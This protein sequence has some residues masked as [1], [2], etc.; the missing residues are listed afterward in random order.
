MDDHTRIFDE[1]RP[2]LLALAYRMLCIRADAEDVLQDAYLRWCSIELGEE[3]LY[4]RAP[5][6]SRSRC[7]GLVSRQLVAQ[8]GAAPR[9]PRAP[10]RPPGPAP[11]GP[12]PAPRPGAPGPRAAA[13]AARASASAKNDSL[14]TTCVS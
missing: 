4:P 8:F 13:R 11:R 10:P 7:V 5:K 2:R 12:A 6:S 9:P 3:I 14:A 1:Q